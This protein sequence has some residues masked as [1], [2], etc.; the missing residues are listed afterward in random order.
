MGKDQSVMDVAHL[1]SPL[2]LR[3]L[4]LPNRIAVSPMCQ[5]SAVDGYANDWH[6]VHLAS[7]AVGGAG[8]I[9][10]EQIAVTPEGRS[11]PQDLG[12]WDDSQ[13][14]PLKRITDFL[15]AQGSYA[16]IQLGHAGRK[17]SM[18]RPWDAPR[19]IPPSE[20]GWENRYSAS[21][22][23]YAEAYGVP[24]PLDLAGIE[25]LKRAYVATT[26]RA[27]EAGFDVAEIHGAHGYLMHQFLSPISNRRTDAYGGSFEGRTR[28]L[29]EVAEAVHKAWPQDRPLFVR[30][31]ATDWLE[32]N[33][34]QET[35]AG[36]GWT[37]DQSIALAKRL[38]EV[39]VD[40]IDVS[41]GGNVA[42][43]HIPVGPGYQTKFAEEI[44][45]EANISTGAVG[46][47]SDPAHAD[48]IL[49]SQQADLILIAREMLRDPYWPMRAARELKQSTPWPV[50]YVRAAE[51]HPEFRS[52]IQL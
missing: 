33:V 5:Y 17:S 15:H 2:S 28:L 4:T 42:K 44:R 12:L 16:G 21:N 30:I 10:T 51:G 11:S 38:R 27:V 23:P 34:E 41:S 29:V 7:R 40:L 8:L 39:G 1:F 52:P 48:H 31:S 26:E 24:I 32:G 50:Q 46:M 25:E 3:E 9:F 43:P 20:G 49:R 19:V 37:F 45:R 47:I 36:S 6:F 35:I 18:S 14:A 13:I 22:V